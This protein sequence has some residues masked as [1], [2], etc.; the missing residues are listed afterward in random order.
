[1]DVDVCGVYC[2]GGAVS[3]ELSVFEVT[4]VLCGSRPLKI[5]PVLS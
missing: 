1:M 3:R 4:M 2:G 5:H